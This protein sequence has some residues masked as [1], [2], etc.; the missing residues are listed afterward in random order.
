M[1]ANKETYR[2]IKKL[3]WF[4]YCTMIIILI[5]H[6]SIVLATE[7]K[8][9]GSAQN[10][11]TVDNETTSEQPIA[12]ALIRYRRQPPRTIVKHIVRPKR[13]KMK[14]VKRPKIK[15][16]FAEPP[17]A[18]YYTRKPTINFKKPTFDSSV[19]EEFSHMN[20]ESANF[21]LPPSSYESQSMDL[22][23]YK[24]HEPII[25]TS[26]KE[27]QKPPTYTYTAPEVS[28]KEPSYSVVQKAPTYSY[29]A[30]EV[31]FKETTK[32]IVTY[33]YA[34]AKTRKP[35]SQYGVPNEYIYTTGYDKPSDNK[36]TFEAPKASKPIYTEV[37]NPYY[38][39]H[40]KNEYTYSKPSKEVPRIPAT[41]YGVPDVHLPVSGSHDYNKYS[42]VEQKPSY[43]PTKPETYHFAE[44]PQPE[45]SVEITYSPSYEINIPSPH[46]NSYSG[47][48]HSPPHHP[49]PSHEKPSYQ[50]Y[51]KYEEPPQQYHPPINH[52]PS[53]SY[54]S[55]PQDNYEHTGPSYQEG[56]DTNQPASY[57]PAPPTGD[58][59]YIP[60]SQ[61]LPISVNHKQPPYDYPKSSYEV[62][63]YDP[64]PFDSSNNQE[65]EIYPPQTLDHTNRQHSS[66]AT[67]YQGEPNNLSE[68]R[69]ES[70][71]ALPDDVHSSGTRPQT[72]L[73]KPKSPINHLRRTRKRKRTKGS[74]TTVSTTKHIL[75][76]PELEEAFEKENRQKH[77]KTQ[78]L[79]ANESH[80]VENINKQ[81]N[82]NNKVY[83]NGPWNPMKIRTSPLMVTTPSS[84][85]S[86]LNIM[87]T[88]N[89][90]F[91]YKQGRTT[92]T[93][94][95]TT[96][97]EAPTKVEIISIEK[98]RSKTFFDGVVSKPKVFN[99]NFFRNR[100][101][102]ES[103][104]TEPPQ[105]MSTN[106]NKV[107]KRTTKNIFDTTIFKSPLTDRDV[108]RNL[109]KNHKLF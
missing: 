98:S 86:A 83:S 45:P 20:V 94:T 19:I 73:Q 23:L 89:R 59:H 1:M 10:L 69:P 8:A 16:S 82:N 93:T 100:Y 4:N 46:E 76:V 31:S 18:L 70:E 58:D 32:P 3:W 9:E 57:Q 74:S 96:T 11:T 56:S 13:F 101:R 99:P 90:R 47:V 95:T 79:D 37:E 102:Q 39:A 15:Y 67:E 40:G 41:S 12:E 71:E 108:Y 97:T 44:P 28:Y 92:A 81:N 35:H 87:S 63:I 66:T 29:T 103:T 17:P 85:T 7:T 6:L 75:D 68:Q 51:P 55:P 84:T 24:H 60:S 33:S 107:S 53:D 106:E 21:D 91:H 78:E 80:Y 42:V 52:S 34:P 109:P 2:T 64:I 14:R 36:Y 25:E 65:R 104:S 54:G 48:K 105:V 38:N 49:P 27:I 26:Y 61:N 88:K 72:T 43:T 30:P 5:L 50:D 22:D 62:P 77:E